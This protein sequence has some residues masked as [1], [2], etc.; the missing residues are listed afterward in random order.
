MARFA[1][2]TVRFERE[3]RSASENAGGWDAPNC[4]HWLAMAEALGYG[5]DCAALWRLGES[6]GDAHSISLDG[7]S[8]PG[9][10]RM[11]ARG[12]LAWH[13]RW[14]DAGPWAALERILR[15]EQP[16]LV[17]KALTG[18]LRVAE[19]GAVSPG[20]AAIV[21]I[22]VVLSV[23]AGYGRIQGEGALV[24]HVARIYRAWPGLPSN[25]IAL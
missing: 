23:A 20:R 9:V 24:R 11:R 17:V 15:I 5:R 21:A 25:Q 18:A 4:T 10:E 19:Q 7:I 8:L 2:H 6:L 13:A 22:N 16:R 3:L 1:E 12:L 14:R